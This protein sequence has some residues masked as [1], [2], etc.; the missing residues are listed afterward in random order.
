MTP[1]GMCA[2][3]ARR[4]AEG[5]THIFRSQGWG[6]LERYIIEQGKPVSSIY[7]LLDSWAISSGI[8]LPFPPPLQPACTRSPIAPTPCHGRWVQSCC[9]VAQPGRPHATYGNTARRWRKHLKS[10][11]MAEH[12]TQWPELP[13]P[14]G[15]TTL[16]AVYGILPTVRPQLLS[17]TVWKLYICVLP[18]QP[19][20]KVLQ[21]WTVSCTF[22]IPLST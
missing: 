20:C 21:W 8:S 15:F 13:G 22:P 17:D 19:D 2:I 7:L 3:D 14:D 5:T 10:S 16:L 11:G 1:I 18:L 4:E 12:A 6:P 9:A